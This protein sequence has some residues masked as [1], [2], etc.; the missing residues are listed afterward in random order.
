MNEAPRIFATFRYR[1]PEMVIKWLCG[2]IGFTMHA[3]HP[4]EGEIAHAEL[5]Y[6]SAMIMLGAVRDDDYGGMVGEPGAQGG[7]STYLAVDDVDALFA[8]VEQSGVVI[9]RGLTDQDYGSRDFLCRDPEDNIWC[10]GT[11]WPKAGG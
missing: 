4:E 6:G 2:A 9:E 3:R 5:A 10:F 1:D 11:Y 7:K 8:R